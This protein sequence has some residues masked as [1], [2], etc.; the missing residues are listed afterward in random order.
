MAKCFFLCLFAGFTI[1][2][3]GQAPLTL[4]RCREL[5]LSNNKQLTASKLSEDIALN[6]RKAAK[7][8]YLPHVNGLAGYEF[9]SREVSILNKDQK[10]ALSNLGT[11]AMGKVSGTVSEVLTSMVQQQ[12]ITPEM[13]HNIGTIMEKMGTPLA[14]KGNDIGNAIR[15][16]FRTDTRNIFAASI[17]VTQ[18]LY[19]GGGITA[20][21][22]MARINQE[23]AHNAVD[24]T[25]QSTLYSIDN[26]YWLAVSLKNKEVLAKQYLELVQKLNTDV[27]KL[28]RE[29]VATRADGLKVDVAVNNAEMSV[30]QVEDGVSLAKMLLCQ[31]CGLPLDSNIT[32]ADE[33]HLNNTLSLDD[34]EMSA[35]QYAANKSDSLYSDRPEVRL[36]ENAVNLS[37]QATKLTRALYRPHVAL[38][39]GVL[40]SNPNTFNG[41]ERKFKEVW[42]IGVLVQVP[43]WSWRE[44]HYKIN[45]TKTATSIAQLELQDLREKI[46]LQVEQYR[47]KV[48]EAQKKATMAR[49]NMASAE[50]NLRCA[51]VGF[52]EGVMTITEVMEAQTAWQ[53]A[54][55]QKIDAEID[56]KLSEVGLRKAL[57]K[58]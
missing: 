2:A 10:W 18:P 34:A 43:I 39:G 45:A 37:T 35:D 57:G 54:Q 4:E 6:A 3:Y 13:A 8:K 25:R 56:V 47:F 41:F 51:N 20:A 26:A 1:T 30:T 27:H 23:L 11:N 48:K 46:A 53:K 50:E 32:L 42:N 5:A 38:T 14:Q 33:Q 44:G 22:E 19:M 58:L 31:L 55:T 36:L 9:F 28:I 29:G 12:L 24:Q 40:V 21:N 17:M 52:R 16:A 7:T 49:K 15:D